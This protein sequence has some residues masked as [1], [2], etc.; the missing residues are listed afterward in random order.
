MLKAEMDAEILRLQ[1]QCTHLE[2]VA[3]ELREWKRMYA[4]SIKNAT[5]ELTRSI[6]GHT[7]ATERMFAAEAR[8]REA[9]ANLLELHH[10]Y[11]SLM[12]AMAAEISGKP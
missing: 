4:P 5:Y 9:G 2:A 7:E 10:R 12:E 3:E 8:E 1:E 11:L 6:A